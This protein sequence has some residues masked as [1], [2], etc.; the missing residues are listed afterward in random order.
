MNMQN[1]TTISVRDFIRDYKNTMNNVIT[2][3]FPVV[4]THRQTPQVAMVDLKSLDKLQEINAPNTANAL[5]E[6]AKEGAKLAKRYKTKYPRD[7][8]TNHD[9]YAWGTYE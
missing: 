8:S 1:L 6:L 3:G 7:I 9:K 4:I 5:L 2:N